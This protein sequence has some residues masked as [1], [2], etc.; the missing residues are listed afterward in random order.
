VGESLVLPFFFVVLLYEVLVIGAGIIGGVRL[1]DS[2]PQ[3]GLFAFIW[4]AITL[5]PAALLNS[6]W[7]GALLY[8][9]VPFALLGGGAVAN[10][11]ERIMDEGS[12]RL[13]GSTFVVTLIIFLSFWIT[14]NLYLSAPGTTPAYSLLI[15]VVGLGLG[16]GYLFAVYSAPVAL[17]LIGMLL[18]LMAGTYSLSTAWSL[19]INH[20]ND[21]REPLVVQ[22]S[23]INLRT[24]VAEL[25]QVSTERYRNAHQIPVGLQSTL[26]Y[27]P[28]WYFRDFRDQREVTGNTDLP[29]AALLDAATPPAAGLGKKVFIGQTWQWTIGDTVGLLRWLKTRGEGNGLG[30]REA[31]LYVQL[32]Q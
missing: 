7:T 13:D 24:S 22:P 32:P 3:W 1:L 9:A 15:P 18:L 19:N 2:R 11:L 30:T 26:G 25:E 23:D 27:A 10:L 29:E 5:L 28:R 6:G 14:L 16:I 31:V 12:W 17:R 20:A 8:I 21:P 4:L